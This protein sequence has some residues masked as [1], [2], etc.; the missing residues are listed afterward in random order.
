MALAGY[1]TMSLINQ[2]LQD[3]EKRRDQ[4][5][6]GH[7]LPTQV[8]AVTPSRSLRPVMWTIPFLVI[9]LSAGILLLRP[10]HDAVS[11]T[12]ATLATSNKPSSE[13][14]F[15]PASQA[16]PTLTAASTP[17]PENLNQELV[18]ESDVSSSTT[19]QTIQ[20]HNESVPV[21]LSQNTT[22]SVMATST[23][24]KLSAPNIETVTSNQPLIQS[25]SIGK[26]SRAPSPDKLAFAGR[27]E[28]VN[29]IISSKKI[30][31][32]TPTRQA[33]SEYRKA[34]QFLQQGFTTRAI[35]SLTQALQNDARHVAARQTMVSILVE[36]K[37]L[38]EAEYWLQEG[39][40]LDRSQSNMAMILARLQVERGDAHAGLETLQGSLSSTTENADYQAFLA[41][42][43]Q[44]EGRHKEAIDHYTQALR[45][46]PQSG[47]WL[48][49]VGISLQAEN[50][51]Q[52]A[53]QAFKQARESKTLRPDL[54][55]FVEQ[56]LQQTRK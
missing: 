32:I 38:D 7:A 5:T 11:A 4:G 23:T 9:G 56:R 52:E 49:G 14:A 17:A 53:Q 20:H 1:I 54:Q 16:Q 34:L 48:M 26:V 21:T 41:A 39:L 40:S 28:N 55:A 10:A 3:L 36:D 27:Q 33:E 44:R 37:R 22:P 15:Q 18:P 46:A 6:V 31:E 45:Q 43:L 8:K 30:K 19:L 24:Q 29:E 47:L 35:E 50:R 51:L 2:M 25:I 42:L 13:T 12:P